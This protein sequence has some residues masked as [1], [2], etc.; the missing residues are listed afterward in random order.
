MFVSPHVN[1]WPPSFVSVVID[2]IK[3]S[4]ESMGKHKG[5]HKHQKKHKKEKSQRGE[6]QVSAYHELNG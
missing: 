2:F 3:V 5:K 1:T 4:L 6:N